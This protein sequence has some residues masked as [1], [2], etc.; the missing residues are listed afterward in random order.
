[1]ALQSEQKSDATA[2]TVCAIVGNYLSSLNSNFHD[3]K[4][5]VVRPSS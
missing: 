2:Y 1:M 4:T 3:P 5:R